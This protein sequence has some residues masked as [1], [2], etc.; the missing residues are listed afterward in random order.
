MLKKKGWINIHRIHNQSPAL[1]H[2]HYGNR[3]A[4][5]WDRVKRLFEENIWNPT[6]MS[7]K[8]IKQLSSRKTKD[9]LD[10]AKVFL[11]SKKE[12]KAHGFDSPDRADAFILSL[13]GLTI[14]DFLQD[15]PEAQKA[16]IVSRP[17]FT[18]QE[19]YSHY[20]DNVTFGD[21]LKETPA[22]GK[23]K[24]HNSLQAALSLE[25]DSQEITFEQASNN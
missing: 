1:N 23:K 15:L 24:V 21:G 2:K 8:C 9:K 4:E 14:E 7:Q 3:G 22:A 25:V 10:G 11:Q 13:T 20:E 6:N 19:M 12:A 5:A 17:R 16:A 18:T